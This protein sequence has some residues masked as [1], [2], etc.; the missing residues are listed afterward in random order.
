LKLAREWENRGKDCFR[1]LACEFFRFGARIYQIYQPHFL[2]EFLLENLKESTSCANADIRKEIISTVKEVV[3][4][5][6]A[7]LQQNGFTKLNTPDFERILEQLRDFQLVE[8]GLNEFS[9]KLPIVFAIDQ[10]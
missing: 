8:T 4:R 5:S 2:A 6:V 3:Q 9:Q 7:S 10:K 1:H